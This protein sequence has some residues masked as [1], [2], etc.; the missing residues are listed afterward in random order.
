MLAS[1]TCREMGGGKL[2]FNTVHL[3]MNDSGGQTS[4]VICNARPTRRCP[5]PRRLSINAAKCRYALAHVALLTSCI[6]L[7]RFGRAD[8]RSASPAHLRSALHIP[9]D[10]A[11]FHHGLGVPCDIPRRSYRTVAHPG[12]YGKTCDRECDDRTRRARRCP[13][14]QSVSYTRS[15]TGR[16]AVW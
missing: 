3:L 6:H 8:A 12:T 10:M 14:S 13:G 15:D 1:F 7:R 9:A 5:P 4:T 11:R 16:K 2:N